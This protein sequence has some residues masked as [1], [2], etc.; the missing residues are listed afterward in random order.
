MIICGILYETV[1]LCSYIKDTE[2]SSPTCPLGKKEEIV[3]KIATFTVI[4]RR[5]KGKLELLMEQLYGYIIQCSNLGNKIT[6][7]QR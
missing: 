6:D 4:K 5:E 1:P 3:S 2:P 7:G